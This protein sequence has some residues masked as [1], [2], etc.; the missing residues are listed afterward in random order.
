MHFQYMTMLKYF[1]A[2]TLVLILGA[3]LQAEEPPVAQPLQLAAPQ[4]WDVQAEPSAQCAVAGCDDWLRVRFHPAAGQTARLLLREP[5]PL[6]AWATDLSFLATNNGAV[7]SLRLFVL[8][9]DATGR[10]F[11]YYTVCPP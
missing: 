4:A 3:S 7:A 11:T 5:I 10:E 6:P 9:R 1:L 8:V 2:F